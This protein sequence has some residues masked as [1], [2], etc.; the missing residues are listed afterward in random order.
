MHANL[1]GLQFT[2]AD[3]QK[4]LDTIPPELEYLINEVNQLVDKEN[5]S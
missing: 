5:K 2:L 1:K 3:M 4:S